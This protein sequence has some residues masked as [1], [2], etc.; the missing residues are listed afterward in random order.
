MMT[1]P[2]LRA[3]ARKTSRDGPGR[4][5]RRSIT[6]VVAA[7]AALALVFLFSGRLP[8]C[9]HCSSDGPPAEGGLTTGGGRILQQ[10][11]PGPSFYALTVAHGVHVE[12]LSV[13]IQSWA[14]YSPSTKLVVFTDVVSLQDPQI[15][16]LFEDYS[17]EAL[18]FDLP[19]DV[20]IQVHRMDEYLRYLEAHFDDIRGVVLSDSADVALQA[21][22]WGEASVLQ[23]LADDAVL[24]TLEGGPQL[25]NVTIAEDEYNTHWIS[26]CFG[27]SMA[28]R[29]G[30]KPISCAGVTIGTAGPVRAYL[31]QMVDVLKTRVKQKCL[32]NVGPDQA[33]HNYLLHY[34]GPQEFLDFKYTVLDN[35]ASPVHT[36]TL[37]FPVTLDEA[38]R[39]RRL[40]TGGSPDP[41]FPAIV[42]QYN[43]HSTLV[44]LY[45]GLYPYGEEDRLEFEEKSGYAG[46]KLPDAE[47]LPA[48]RKDRQRLTP[49]EDLE[50]RRGQ[51]L[52]F[53]EAQQAIEA[54]ASAEQQQQP[55]QEQ[56]QAEPRHPHQPKD[57][58][59]GH[60]H[61]S[62]ERQ[63][64][65]GATSGSHLHQRQRESAAAM[66][67]F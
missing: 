62:A 50:T 57:R 29:L 7:G 2:M 27:T 31:R 52:A 23:L 32:R 40:P 59:A 13:Y 56:Q 3:P 35:W 30:D 45:L 49:G 43:R 41:A 19:E 4:S 16:R 64:P 10:D 34:L 15:S 67:A 20:S 48:F 61:N 55:T 28:T 46:D 66:T 53:L 18:P 63:G 60:G 9:I 58:T 8:G 24:F 38:R 42:H 51:E 33:A 11:L 37:A 17:V 22:P 65:A 12:W 44:K 36:A 6:R 26:D 47:D 14:R 54:L 25:G 39:L 1:H 5:R 21:D